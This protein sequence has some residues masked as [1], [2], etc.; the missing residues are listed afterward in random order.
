MRNNMKV[1]D[2]ERLMLLMLCDI[3]DG[4]KVRGEFDTDFIR[5]AIF[6]EKLWS[7]PW[8]YSGIPF[9]DQAIPDVVKE[10]ID[11]LDMWSFIEYSVL[12]LNEEDRARLDREAAPFGRDPKFMGFD[13]NNE[14]E[15]MS[16][17]SFFVNH[18]DRFTEFKGRDFN[19][20]MP[21]VDA[22]RRMLQPYLAVRHKLAQGPLS[23]DDLI[24]ILSEQTHPEY[25]Q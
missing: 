8:K 21:T 4:T 19:S 3:Y 9:E 5:S 2:A 16:T 17:A 20:H 22:Y 18:L 7:L 24:A 10:V 25:G 6:G 14:A 15:Y 12:K 11:I 13:G 23:V 1:S